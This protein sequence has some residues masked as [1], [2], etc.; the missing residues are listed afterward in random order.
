M[1]YSSMNPRLLEILQHALGLDQYG[2]GAAYRN[3]FC[4]GG[5]DEVLCEELVAMGYM[6][7]HRTTEVFPDANFSVTDE[8]RRAVREQSPAPPKLTRSQQRYRRYLD[9]DSG[10]SFIEWL[11]YYGNGRR[12]TA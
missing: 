9:A 5:G 10:L 1:S 8:G 7:R 2:R 3:H 6:R 4:A 12:W 11:K